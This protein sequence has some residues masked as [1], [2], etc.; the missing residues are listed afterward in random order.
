MKTE[1]KQGLNIQ[2]EA[3]AKK[4]LGLPTE[5]GRS[6][7]GVFE[8]L[9]SQVSGGIEGWCAREASYAGREVQIKSVAQAVPRY[10][11]SCF[12][13]P[14]NTCKK[15]KSVMAKYWWGSSADN[16]RMH[17]MSWDRLIQPKC[18]GVMGF[19]DIRCFIHA[20][21]GKQGTRF[22]MCKSK[23]RYFH[24]TEFMQ[25]SRKKHASSIWRA[26]LAGREVLQLGLIK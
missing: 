7:S 13:L 11:I 23:G 21:L 24:D 19:R 16:R 20:M 4:Y 9:P 5:V 10:S 26:V 22:S 17:W 18:N 3:L 14:I 2:K 8:F 25:A 12:L 15:M 1:V 6:L